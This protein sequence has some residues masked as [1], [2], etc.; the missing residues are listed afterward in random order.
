MF[1]FQ[2]LA[3]LRLLLYNALHAWQ[4]QVLPVLDNALK[5]AI[6]V[7]AAD[8][9]DVDYDIVAVTVNDVRCRRLR[10]HLLGFPS[11]AH[12]EVLEMGVVAGAEAAAVV[13]DE[14][15]NRVVEYLAMNDNL[16]VVYDKIMLVVVD[17]TPPAVVVDAVDLH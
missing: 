1:A 12:R 2:H 15:C 9:S 11:T 10:C 3:Y 5:V 16:V 13:V 8:N 4:E 7:V 17:Y 6:V 14:V